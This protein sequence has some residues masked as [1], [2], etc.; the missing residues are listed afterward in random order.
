[1][2]FHVIRTS[3]PQEV[4]LIYTYVTKPKFGNGPRYLRDCINNAF[5][6][7]CLHLYTSEEMTFWLKL[8]LP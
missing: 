7:A 3:P 1:M 2:V 4:N 6:H 8:L 5:S